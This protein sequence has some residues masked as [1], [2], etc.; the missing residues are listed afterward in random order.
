FRYNFSLTSLRN[1]DGT[2]AS[3][4]REYVLP[5]AHADIGGGYHNHDV[6][7]VLLMPDITVA[8]IQGPKDSA[9]YTRT[10]E[11]VE[12]EALIDKV[13][14]AG[15]CTG[16]AIYLEATKLRGAAENGVHEATFVDRS[17]E[18]RQ[19]TLIGTRRQIR[20]SLRM[21]RF[22]RNDYSRIPLYLMHE[23]A[24]IQGVPFMDLEK[25]SVGT[26]DSDPDAAPYKDRKKLY[27]TRLS[28]P[29][30]QFWQQLRGQMRQ[31]DTCPLGENQIHLLRRFWLHYSANWEPEYK[32][33]HPHAPAKKRA[34]YPNA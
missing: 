18:T 30:A 20:L 25:P 5:G 33:L 31:G 19:K 21:S 27:G 12:R 17:G 7:H 23:A 24:Q 11:Y 6:D 2:L 34:V 22:M 13:I 4:C 32:V 10:P 3:N 29:L 26:S 28:G 14:D 15:W 8:D 16:D 9:P 1:R